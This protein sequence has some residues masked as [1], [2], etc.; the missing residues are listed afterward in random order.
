MA[1]ELSERRLNSIRYISKIDAAI[2]EEASEREEYEKDPIKNADKLVMKEGQ[3]PTVFVLNFEV[4]AK[5]A[6]SIKDSRAKGFS[7]D[8]VQM[9]MGDW[10]YTVCKIV[11][12]GIVNPPGTKGVVFKKDGRGYVA[13]S[14]MDQLEKFNLVDEIWALYVAMTN[15]E[16]EETE[17][18][19]N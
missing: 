11:L 14:T 9:S 15:A 4:N 10:A 16:Q 3:E 1:I 13:D 6:K 2:D 18:S 19:P 7:D 5:E 8:T 17:A 12:K